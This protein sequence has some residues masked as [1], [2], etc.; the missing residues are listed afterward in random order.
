MASPSRSGSVASTRC[1]LR[2][3]SRAIS[4]MRPSAP[5]F[6]CQDMANPAGGGA[7]HPGLSRDSSRPVQ[8]G[9][10]DGSA[11]PGNPMSRRAYIHARLHAFRL[12]GACGPGQG[13]AC[14]RLHR[15]LLGRHVNG[16]LRNG[17]AVAC[18]GLVVVLDLVLLG[19]SVVGALG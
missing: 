18:V 10:Q 7:L 3:T 8:P 16:R 4:A 11:A 12:V 2:R 13:L 17:L 9:R 15:A 1:L 14:L 5:L 19:S 6:S